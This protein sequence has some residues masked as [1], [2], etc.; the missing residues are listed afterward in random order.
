MTR[1]AGDRMRMAAVW[2]LT[3]PALVSSTA[4]GMQDDARDAK[5]SL[6]QSIEWSAGPTTASV[7]DEAKLTVPQGC[8]YTG[9]AGAKTF[10]ELTE[11]P[12]SG[13]EQGI[14]LCQSDATGESLWFVVFSFDPS[15]YVKD[16][17]GTSLDADAILKSIKRGTEE[18][19]RER[20]KRG[21]ETINIDG[22]VRSPYYDKST[23]NL[24]WSLRALSPSGGAT[25]N[26]SVRLLGRGGVMHADLVADAEG[27]D[28]AVKAFDAIIAS[29]MFVP[30]RTYAE[31]REGDKIASYGLT[32]LVAGG[33]GAALVKTGLLAKLGRLII[34]LLIAFKKLIVVAVVGIGAWLK[35]LFRRKEQAAAGATGSAS[36]G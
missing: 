34:G 26:H 28:G 33:V 12:T 30:G 5:T 32:A 35:S 1:I 22:W 21:W 36:P 11:N 29:H 20:R 2:A 23:H 7:G 3:L 19:N 31:W 9:P 24:T 27:L 8:R 6:F 4:L 13:A 18:G 15:G 10:M 16:D 17:D 14:L 25:V